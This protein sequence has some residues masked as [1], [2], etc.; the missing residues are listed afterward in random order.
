MLKVMY[1]SFNIFILIVGMVVCFFMFYCLLEKLR[2]FFR[3]NLFLGYGFIVFKFW[4]M[5]WVL[6]IVSE[7]IVELWIKEEREGVCEV[8]GIFFV[9]CLCVNYYLDYC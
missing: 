1:G 8:I 7:I 4:Y 3:V 5:Y 9:F 2:L 6:W